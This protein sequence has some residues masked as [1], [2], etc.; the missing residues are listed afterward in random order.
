LIAKERVWRKTELNGDYGVDKHGSGTVMH[1][2]IPKENR[3][4]K[5]NC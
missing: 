5:L 1:G 4:I 3:Q 2:R